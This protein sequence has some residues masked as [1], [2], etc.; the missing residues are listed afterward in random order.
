MT[1]YCADGI[2]NLHI[3]RANRV[4]INFHKEK[5]MKRTISILVIVAMM[6]ASL[7]A[8]VPVS[9]AEPEGTP[10]KNAKEF[11]AMEA[12]GTYYLANDITISKPYADFKGTLDGNGHTI[13]ANGTPSVF[14]K[15]SGATVSNLNIV[16]AVSA[17]A[18]SSHVGALAGTANG[19]FTNIDVT[20]DFQYSG[21]VAGHVGGLIGDVNGATIIDTCKTYG[22][23]SIP[24]ENF[25]NV[26]TAACGG[27][28][29]FVGATSLDIKNCINYVEVTNYTERTNVGGILGQA[30]G[31]Y[32]VTIEG[33]ANFGTIHGTCTG[34]G[35]NVH[36]GAGGIVGQFSANSQ[37]NAVGTVK[38]SRNYADVIIITGAGSGNKDKMA[39]GIVGRIY[40]SKTVYVQDCVNS[41][42]VTNPG[43]GWAASGGIV[44]QAETYNYT[45]SNSAECD[46]EVISCI[47]L[48]KINGNNAGGIFGSTAQIATSGLIFTFTNC[49]NF[50]EV[51]ANTEGNAGG[52][53]GA[54]SSDAIGTFNI[55]KC[56][57][58]GK[59]N[60]AGIFAKTSQVKPT[61]SNIADTDLTKEIGLI[62]INQCINVG[63]AA[64]AMIG[65]YTGPALVI[66]ASANT[67]EG[68]ELAPE[69]EVIAISEAPADVAAAIEALLVELPS[70]PAELDVVIAENMQNEEVDYKEGWDVFKAAYDKAFAVAIKSSNP[71]EMKAAI[72]ELNAAVPALVLKDELDFE[73]LDIAIGEADEF[74]DFEEDFTPGTWKLFQEAYEAANACAE[75]ER[76][77]Q[78]NKAAKTLLSAID[79]L[80]TKPDFDKLDAAMAKYDG[81]VEAEYTTTS[82][83]AFAAALE[84]AKAVRANTEAVGSDVDAAI[85]ALNA[86]GKAL[87]KKVESTDALKARVDE[88][89]AKYDKEAYTSISYKPLTDAI[90]I[91]NG[92]I[93]TK[94]VSQAEIDAILKEFDAH[95]AAL[96][97]RADLTEL[98]ALVESS[99]ALV[100]ENYSAESWAAFAEALKA[101]QNACKIGNDAKVSVDEGAALKAALEAA[102]TAL[103]GNADYTALDALLAEVKALK[104]ADYTAETWKVLADAI[105]AAEALKANTATITTDVDA[106]IEAI[107]AAKGALA[108]AEVP[109]EKPTEQPTEEPTEPAKKSGCGGFIATSVAVVAVVSVLGTAVALKK[110]ED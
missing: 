68:I 41:G 14:T 64:F 52:I 97:P 12:T 49:I 28:V 43:T 18:P 27:M 85:D 103:V 65:A 63:E 54:T 2:I 81:L 105:A 87:G 22:V 39:G 35:G 3:T 6:L 66:K 100:E 84:A 16:A 31:N 34:N 69:S 93:D 110:K 55:T 11:A 38:N 70:D 33:C 7:L 99:A 50:G 42:N 60:G 77:S 36:C 25:S 47:N 51:V 104:E 5:D 88:I 92:Y 102:L 24:A 76:Q 83:A 91:A 108:K 53:F 10:V 32:K 40:G 89:F 62:T 57:N 45:W 44:G 30:N 109:T 46:I 56:Y 71:A 17:E 37:P 8:I 80:E 86:A 94:D 106:A 29:A 72:D 73:V 19:V 101:A 61:D 4:I 15:L 98:K 79:A 74:I 90:R 9:A 20:V 82:W 75:A 59:V 1:K 23:I 78:I 67:F 95:I 107:N 58:A 96:L 48:G 26:E 13:T 21:K